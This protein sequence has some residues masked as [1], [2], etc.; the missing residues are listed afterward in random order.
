[1]TESET[2]Q[3]A[4]EQILSLVWDLLA[5]GVSRSRDP[6]HCPALAT[7]SAQGCNVRKVILRHADEKAR[8]L[9]CF[10]DARAAKVG[11]IREH[12]H[13][14]WLFYHPRKQIQLRISGQATVHTDDQ[15]ADIHWERV[16]GLSRLNY[17]TEQAPGTRVDEPSSGLPA[18]LARQL[19]NLVHTNAGRPNFAVIVGRVETIDWLRLSKTGNTRAR[20]NWEAGRLEACWVVP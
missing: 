6:M 17:C 12:G 20:F 5:K 9:I 10:S 8:T 7:G 1:M 4:L 2:D 3:E 19:S 15:A 13:V 11:E 18:R 14:Q 16:K